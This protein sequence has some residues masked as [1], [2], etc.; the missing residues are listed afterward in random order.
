MVESN[1]I[2]KHHNYTRFGDLRKKLSRVV[3][4]TVSIKGR[5]R[6]KDPPSVWPGVGSSCALRPTPA[7]GS[8]KKSSIEVRNSNPDELD[9][10]REIDRVSYNDIVDMIV[11]EKT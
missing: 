11:I 5:T 10:L 4:Y 8:I 9:S 1:A 3:P 2:H 6:P 7:P